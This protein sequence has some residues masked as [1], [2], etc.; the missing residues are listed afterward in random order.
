M[1][2]HSDTLTHADIADATRAAGMTG[3]YT[4]N[5][6][7]RGSRSRDHGFEVTLRGTS[8]RRP[9][10]G[11]GGRD[12]DPDERAATWDEWGMF[13]HALFERDPEAIVGMYASQSAFDAF[14]C[15]RFSH[16]TADHQHRNHR[17]SFDFVD[18]RLA[19]KCGAV[20]DR[21]AALLP[22]LD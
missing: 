12:Y 21:A 5:E 9:N 8:G 20:Q 22:T 16:L 19:C 13:I 10:P 14:T 7:E 4:A 3:V 1:K 11:T 2:I 15:G 6:F 18:R 17:W